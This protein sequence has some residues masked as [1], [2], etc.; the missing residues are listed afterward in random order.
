[1][2]KLFIVAIATLVILLI[3]AIKLVS[4]YAINELFIINYNNAD[5]SES[6]IKPLYWFN[7]I[8]P[9]N[10]Y[11]NNGNVLYKTNDFNGAIEKY[12]KA[13]ELFPGDKKECKIRIN[14]C[15]AM[16][17]KINFNDIQEDNIEKILKDLGDAKEVLLEHGCANR[18]DNS[19]H[20][21]DAIQLK[22]EIE[23]MENKLKELKQ[24]G[25]EESKDN[26]KK[27]DEDKSKEEQK[28][29]DEIEEKI[30]EIRK[31]GVEERQE[32]QE[33]IE[34]SK[35]LKEYSIYYKGKKW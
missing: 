15:L 7:F 13:L 2:K 8:E 19:G 4:T 34:K 22:K 17:K 24:D 26:D 35:M 29:S 32:K 20:N 14:L 18:N 3:I 28:G 27:K 11:Y 16:L 31:Q 10:V 5:Y 9:C 12:K 30:K 1:M 21:K 25:E 6:I 23:E 33:I